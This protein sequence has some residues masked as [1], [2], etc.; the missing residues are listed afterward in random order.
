MGSMCARCSRSAAAV[1]AGVA[2]VGIGLGIINPDPPLW[3]MPVL[4]LPRPFCPSGTPAIASAVISG[5][6]EPSKLREPARFYFWHSRLPVLHPLAPYPP[7]P[8]PFFESATIL[9]PASP[10]TLQ[11]SPASDF[12]LSGFINIVGNPPGFHSQHSRFPIVTRSP[13]VCSSPPPLTR[14]SAASLPSV[15]APQAPLQVCLPAIA[16]CR[17]PSK[18]WETHPASVLGT[19]AS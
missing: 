5:C 10:A 2:A 3:S 16:G 12:G 11:T 9:V 1:G 17:E 7:L 8:H 15:P 6:L 14:S 19:P 4:P 18:S 13:A